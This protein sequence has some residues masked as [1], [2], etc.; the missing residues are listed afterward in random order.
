MWENWTRA[1]C[2]DGVRVGN[3]CS[4]HREGWRTGVGVH[5]GGTRGPVSVGLCL[6]G[7]GGDGRGL[8]GVG[9]VAPR[10]LREAVP[11]LVVGERGKVGRAPDG[12]A[13]RYGD[14]G[15]GRELVR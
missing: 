1:L 9:G 5:G 6:S 10:G 7:R 12:V 8:A 11:R 13:P 15:D 4:R 2:S 14:V 3:S